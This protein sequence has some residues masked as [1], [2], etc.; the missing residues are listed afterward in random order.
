MRVKYDI[1]VLG[2]SVVNPRARTGVFRV[3][4]QLVQ[5]LST[6]PEVELEFSA[7]FYPSG[8]VQYRDSSPSLAGIPL[9]YPGPL[10]KVET[11]KSDL[12]RMSKEH[13]FPAKQGLKVAR[14][15]VGVAQQLLKRLYRDAQQRSLQSCDIF[16][17][18]FHPLPAGLGGCQKFITVYDLIP[19]LFPQYFEFREDHLLNQVMASIDQDT[20][21][22]C[23]SEATKNDL[24][25]HNPRVD[26]DK[27]AVVPLGASSL[28]YRCDDQADLRRVRRQ[29]GIPEGP[30][31]LSVATLEPRKNIESTIKAFVRLV[32]EEKLADCSLVLAGAK[33]WDFDRIFQEIAG[34]KGLEERII[35]TG[36]VEDDDLAPL[37]SGALAFVYPSHYEGFGLP[38]LEAMQCGTPVIS[39]NTSSL[40]E[41]VGEAGIQVAPLDNDALCQAMLQ[42]FNDGALREQLA[43]RSRRRAT[44]FSWEACADVTIN[45]YRRALSQSGS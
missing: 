37:Y 1:S 25:N 19:I 35:V 15:L 44:L 38:P 6:R 30:Y 39:S 5:Q 11:A 14:E 42:L 36:Y 32:R 13:G 16:H 41:V 10:L 31:F 2:A 24:L 3:V 22:F 45:H 18:P 28:F 27:V 20:W 17:S 26:A 34:A 23:I 4:E 12:S 40:P 8:A 33:G 43:G 7:L 9:Y 29:Y 21:V